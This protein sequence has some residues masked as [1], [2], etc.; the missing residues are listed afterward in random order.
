M[1]ARDSWSSGWMGYNFCTLAYHLPPHVLNSPV[2]FIWSKIIWCAFLYNNRRYRVTETISLI[3]GAIWPP[4]RIHERTR[5]PLGWWQSWFPRS[6]LGL[7]MDW[8]VKQT[9]FDTVLIIW[10]LAW[11]ILI[12]SFQE[13][14]FIHLANCTFF[15]LAGY[16]IE[17]IAFSWWQNSIKP[18]LSSLR[19][20]M[21]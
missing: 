18:C 6:L 15:F 12:V 21:Q 11:L 19:L 4:V 7:W 5:D 1:F 9:P 14:S 17:I 10:T 3:L 20:D 16:N 8:S 13:H 2:Y